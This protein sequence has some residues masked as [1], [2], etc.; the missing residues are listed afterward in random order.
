MQNTQQKA[1]DLKKHMGKNRLGSWTV[2]QNEK[3]KQEKITDS[4]NQK[5]KQTTSWTRKQEMN[6]SQK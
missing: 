6:H 2:Q 4:Q 1:K 3:D 5:I